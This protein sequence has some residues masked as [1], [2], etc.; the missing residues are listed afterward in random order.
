MTIPKKNAFALQPIT[1]GDDAFAQKAVIL[2][3]DAGQ[4][5]DWKLAGLV[6]EATPEEVAETKGEKPA[7]AK[8]RP[9]SR[10]KPKMAA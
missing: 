10:S 1:H 8:P 5:G 9:K 4:F 2:G 7:P 6:R 3:M